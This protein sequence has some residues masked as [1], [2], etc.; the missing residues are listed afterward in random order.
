MTRTAFR[1]AVAALVLAGLSG[2]VESR[3]R[4]SDDFGVAVRQDVAAQIADPDAQYR[5]NPAP[6]SDGERAALATS[7]YGHDDVTPPAA[8]STQTS[9]GGGSS[10]GSR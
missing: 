8:A 7:R 5:G 1:I 9:V 3:L 6:A 2:C 4:Q 10:G